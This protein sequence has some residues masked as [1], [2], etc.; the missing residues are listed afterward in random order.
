MLLFAYSLLMCL[1][2][3]LWQAGIL[4]AL[5]AGACK[6]VLQKA[7][8]AGRRN[9]LLLA[10][11]LQLATSVVSFLLYYLQPATELAATQ[12]AAY[13]PTTDSIIYMI[14]PWLI[15]AYFL[16]L[17]VRAI[18]I[19]LSWY[20]FS[21]L[22]KTG[23]QKPSADLKVFT[24]LTAHHLGIRKNVQLWL[25]S[26]I[27]TPVV[28]GYFKP[29]I[30]LPVALVN[31]LSLQ[32]AEA[33]VVHELTHIRVNDYLLN[34]FLSAAEIIFFFNP[35]V[36][37]LCGHAKLEREKHCD[38]NVLYFG[39][40]ALLY[41]ET[42]LLAAKMQQ[43]NKHWQLAATGNKKTLLQRIH[44]FTS[45]DVY[46][47]SKKRTSLVFAPLMA[48]SIISMLCILMMIPSSEKQRS[49]AIT[50]AISTTYTATAYNEKQVYK[51]PE[52]VLQPAKQISKKTVPKITP[53][54][55]TKAFVSAATKLFRDELPTM[56]ERAFVSVAFTEN[57]LDK[58]IIIEEQAS[59]SKS[60]SLKVYVASFKNGQWVLTPKW[61]A[62]SQKI[63]VDTNY[64]KM[65]SLYLRTEQ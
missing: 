9:L 44:F 24:T 6:T 15:A 47:F 58:E 37:K 55:K 57:E 5:Y 23:L 40:N 11:A 54:R 31:Q 21:Q 7:A 26:T 14:S 17:A 27:S 43:Q 25:S 3:S 63:L 2:H 59:G 38:T 48:F 49:N 35:F 18:R 62:Q 8:P 60:K 45:S 34:W 30:L 4:Y 20:R 39:S 65:D 52:P 29:I 12:L 50:G 61:I 56:Q 36:Q 64:I 33:L 51:L 42:L 28:F 32:Q 13:L 10:I 16:V 22:Y 41:A 1:L 53:D 19:C 46:H